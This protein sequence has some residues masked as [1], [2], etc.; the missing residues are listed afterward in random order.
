MEYCILPFKQ[1]IT[2]YINNPSSRNAF[3]YIDPK[4]NGASS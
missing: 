4:R 1:W 2:S 3:V